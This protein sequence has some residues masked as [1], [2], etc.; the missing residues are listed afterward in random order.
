MTSFD[1]VSGVNRV[2]RATTARFSGLCVTKKRGRLS[3]A[4]NTEG[5]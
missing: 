4:S 5:Q 1:G 2:Q 3:P